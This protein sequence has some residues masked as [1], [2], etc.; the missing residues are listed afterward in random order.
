MKTLEQVM[1][2]L[3]TQ[4]SLSYG[5]C[6][7]GEPKEGQHPLE[8]PPKRVTVVFQFSEKGF[9]FGEIAIVQTPQGVFVDTE[10]M[11]PDRVKKYLA[12]L[13][14]SATHDT[15]QDPE[16]HALYNQVMGRSCG[17]R[18]LACFPDGVEDE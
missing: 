15:E 6:V 10:C 13:V 16:K 7:A 11:N 9:G 4:V 8:V 12:S 3:P 1:E 14:D 5:S 18:C 2:C 17:G